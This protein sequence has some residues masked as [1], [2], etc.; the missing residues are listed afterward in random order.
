M[1]KRFF[2]IA[3]VFLFLGAC[4]PNEKNK[5]DMRSNAPEKGISVKEVSMFTSLRLRVVKRYPHVVIAADISGNLP[6]SCTSVKK[7]TQT[8]KNDVIFIKIITQRPKEI[9]CAQALIPFKKTVKID[10]SRL[11]KGKYTV[12]AGNLKAEFE[13]GIAAD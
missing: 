9:M 6:D 3:F 8:L 1:G 12:V 10:T 5:K 2:I 13:T 11:K 4:A 7:I